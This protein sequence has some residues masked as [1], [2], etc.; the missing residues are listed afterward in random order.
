MEQKHNDQWSTRI[1][2]PAEPWLGHIAMLAAVIAGY[3]GIFPEL[4]LL[5]VL[6]M[7]A[8]SWANLGNWYNDDDVGGSINNVIQ[9]GT[10]EFIMATI[11]IGIMGGGGV[12]LRWM[13]DRYL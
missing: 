1:S 2:K 12:L 5:L 8:H 3:G 13:G 9:F 10:G 4:Y 6:V 7:A 11:L